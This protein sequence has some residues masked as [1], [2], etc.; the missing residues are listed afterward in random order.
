MIKNKA[1]T[2]SQFINEAH[3][4]SS[5]ELEGLN[6]S[7]E[8]KA[9]LEIYDELN[10]ISEFLEDSGARRVRI[11]DPTGH[12]I[13]FKFE[14]GSYSYFMELDLDE[15]MIT[16]YS[17]SPRSGIPHEIYQ[18]SAQ[19]FFDLAMNTGLDFLLF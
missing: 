19:G 2:Y 13:I 11:A 15:D 18:D 14:Y 3:I 17:K 9:E 12:P 8:E 4:N 1:L 6:F 7:P 10:T 5:G 16:V